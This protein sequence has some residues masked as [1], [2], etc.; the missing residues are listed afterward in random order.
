M[1]DKQKLRKNLEFAAVYERG[2]TW[3]SELIILK[4]LSNGLE[5][6][7]Y[8]FVAGKRIG[9]AVVRNR[10]KRRLREVTRAIPT[11]S[12]WDLVLMARSPAVTANYHELKAAV[13]GLLRR[14][15]ILA[16]KDEVG[17]AERASE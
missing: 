1:G 10:V 15:R 17:G 13:A 8:G 4:T 9:K 12:G 16:E 11:K 14:A 5:W 6:S 3:A 2:K 7:R